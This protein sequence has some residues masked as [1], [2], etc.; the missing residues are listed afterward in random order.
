MKTDDVSLKT[1]VRNEIAFEFC[2]E[3]CANSKSWWLFCQA[4]LFNAMFWISFFLLSAVKVM[5]LVCIVGDI[6]KRLVLFDEEN[7]W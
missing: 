6:F 2:S 5:N 7:V 4:T 3:R 1:N